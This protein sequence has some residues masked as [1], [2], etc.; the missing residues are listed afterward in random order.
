MIKALV[1]LIL[2]LVLIG[3]KEELV[4]PPVKDIDLI[5]LIN[6]AKSKDIDMRKHDIMTDDGIIALY[7]AVK[8]KE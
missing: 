6:E 2:F 1:F 4:I 5:A 8:T 3:C 7:I